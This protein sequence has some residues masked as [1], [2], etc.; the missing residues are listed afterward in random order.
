M[1]TPALIWSLTV[2]IATA[3]LYACGSSGRTMQ[4]SRWSTYHADPMA[5]ACESVPARGSIVSSPD[6]L[7][8]PE[9]TQYPDLQPASALEVVRRLRPSY[10]W[11]SI[12]AKS[13]LRED[14]RVIV[15]RSCENGVSILQ[16]IPAARVSAIYYVAPNEAIARYGPRYAGGIILVFTSN[17]AREVSR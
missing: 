16:R 17:V 1:K 5:Y 13:T 4:L 8:P 14:P 11:G 2:V 3:P 15:D 9:I 7:M 6:R 10:L 12:H